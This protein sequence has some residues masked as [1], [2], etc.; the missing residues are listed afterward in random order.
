MQPGASDG[1][2]S[3]EVG[4]EFF[5]ASGAA[6]EVFESREGAFDAVS[7]FVEVFIV[8]SLLFA[9]GFRRD[10]RDGSSRFNMRDDRIGVVTLVGQHAPSLS[11]PSGEVH[12]FQY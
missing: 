5:I 11:Y 8:L 10:D 1:D 3:L 2:D 6:T 9:I 7:L 4:F 12:A